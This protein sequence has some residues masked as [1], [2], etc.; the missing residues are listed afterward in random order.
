MNSSFSL[1]P[2]S[3]SAGLGPTHTYPRHFL[4]IKKFNSERRPTADQV[5]DTLDGLVRYLSQFEIGTTSK[6]RRNLPGWLRKRLP[7]CRPAEP[8]ASRL[9][10]APGR[11]EGAARRPG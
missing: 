6:L 4:C 10:I 1:D 11:G 9:C 8:R 5:G 7:G 3:T 2:R